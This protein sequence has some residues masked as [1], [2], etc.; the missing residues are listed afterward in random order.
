MKKGLLLLLAIIVCFGIYIIYSKENNIKKSI[1]S[2]APLHISE[3]NS[4]FN[5]AT[6][7]LLNSYFNLR[8]AFVNWS[9]DSTIQKL[10]NSLILST[11][12]I[13][14]NALKADTL[15]INTAKNFASSLLAESNG[16]KGDSMIAEQRRDF[17]NISEN[18]YNFLR[19]VHYDQATI[20]HMHCPMAFD[21]DEAYWLSADTT[22][23]NPYF[24]NKD[25]KVKANMLHCG[26]I[27]DSINFRK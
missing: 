24:G 21:G 14:F 26:D 8:D 9:P 15:L 17:Y 23:I 16:L 10:N 19:T 20:Y 1:S 4:T 2:D 5:S 11:N 13:P 7:A 22:I 18:L 6:A 12:K 3:N 25:P 27:E